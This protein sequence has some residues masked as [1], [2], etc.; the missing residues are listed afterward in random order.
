MK[1]THQLIK[2]KAETVQDLKRLINQTGTIS[3]DDL[4]NSMIH[5]TDA[6]R[7]GLKE[8]GWIAGITLVLIMGFVLSY[9]F[10]IWIAG[11]SLIY[12][13]L[14]QKKDDENLLERKDKEEQEEERK[15]E[16]E[17]RKRKEEEKKR[18][19]EKTEEASEGEEKKGDE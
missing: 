4:I 13:I 15:R 12:I 1:R 8:A 10:S 18:E 19:E 14:R 17:E 9:S 16:E 3:L 7:L 5:L 2:L 11:Q 6:H